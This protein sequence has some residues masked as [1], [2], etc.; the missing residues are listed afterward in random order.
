MRHLI[1]PRVEHLQTLLLTRLVANLWRD[2]ACLASWLVA[3]PVLGEGQAEV[4]H[5]MI[6]LRDVAHE[7]ADLAIV[8]L[9]PVATP[10]PFDAHR[11]RAPVGETPG[12][13]P[14]DAP[15]PPPPIPP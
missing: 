1:T 15:A 9:P 3:C 4:E 10:L 5:G 13:T 8:D 7:D 11:A 2:V 6:V 14:D 12:I